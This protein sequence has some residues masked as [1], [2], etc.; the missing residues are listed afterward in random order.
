LFLIFVTFRS[1]LDMYLLSMLSAG[2]AFSSSK[3]S[4]FLLWSKSVS[5]IKI[6]DI[7]RDV[8]Y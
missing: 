1:Q 2:S 3:I 7:Q 4:S 6:Y 8:F 5:S